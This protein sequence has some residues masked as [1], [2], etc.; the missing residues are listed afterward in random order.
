MKNAILIIASTML[1][2]ASC[3]HDQQDQKALSD[4]NILLMQHDSLR[5]DS[6]FVSQISILTSASDSLLSYSARKEFKAQLWNEYMELL[7]E[8]KKE[9]TKAE[10]IEKDVDDGSIGGNYLSNQAYLAARNYLA[11]NGWSERDRNKMYLDWEC[12]HSKNVIRQR[13]LEQELSKLNGD[14]YAF[15][16]R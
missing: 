2:F 4:M 1:F 5:K 9:I 10:N 11:E 16:N 6:A 7:S 8:K 13:A 14:Y 3:N 15:K 12:M